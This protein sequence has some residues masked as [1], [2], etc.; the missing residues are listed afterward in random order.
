LK[1]DVYHVYHARVNSGRMLAYL[2]VLVA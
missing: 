1:R 2:F